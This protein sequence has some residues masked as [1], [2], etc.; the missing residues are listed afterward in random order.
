M[1]TFFDEHIIKSKNFGKGNKNFI[2]NILKKINHTNKFNIFNII[3]NSVFLDIKSKEI[4]YYYYQKI[5]TFI[6]FIKKKIGH[7]KSKKYIFD[8][9]MD[10]NFEPLYMNSKN[11]IPLFHYDKTYYFNIFDILKIIKNALFYNEELFTGSHMPKNPFNNKEFT[12]VN[13]INI[14]LLMI[15][16]NFEM[17]LYFMLFYKSS[18]DI[19]KF[20]CNYE[21]YIRNEAI[22]NY[23]NDKDEQFIYEEIIVM[24]RQ[25]KLK[26]LYVHPDFSKK[27]IVNLFLKYLKRHLLFKFSYNPTLIDISY[28]KNMEYFLQFEKDNPIFGRIYAKRGIKINKYKYTNL[29]SNKIPKFTSFSDIYNFIQI[30]EEELDDETLDD[31]TLNDFYDVN[32]NWINNLIEQEPV[33]EEIIIECDSDNDNIRTDNINIRTD[34]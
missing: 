3:N 33:L 14:Y 28:K 31:E 12:I 34:I 8:N 18:F 32:L 23:Y 4:F 10:L 6:L 5:I 11:T 17:P 26:K 25:Y 15:N 9:F 24:L 29:I 27:I 19:D 13:L 21:P 16:N 30:E 1:N 2:Y 7:M 22:N 20:T